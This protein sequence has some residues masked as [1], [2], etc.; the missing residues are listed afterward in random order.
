[1][2][3]CEAVF[4]GVAMCL[5]IAENRV[6]RAFLCNPMLLRVKHNAPGGQVVV[7]SNL[8]TSTKEKA[9]PARAFFISGNDA[10]A[11]KH[12]L[13]E[14]LT[15]TVFDR[16]MS[17]I[18]DFCYNKLFRSSSIQSFATDTQMTEC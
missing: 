15:E 9:R 4:A 17:F 14:I 12:Q 18:R 8:A 13:T 2:P 10:R 3:L 7:S 16:Q 1:M 5:E 6:G 11:R